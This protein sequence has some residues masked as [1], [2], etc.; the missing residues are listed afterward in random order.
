MRETAVGSSVGR[1]T[2]GYPSFSPFLSTLQGGQKVTETV[3]YARYWLPER[4]L[5]SVRIASIAV[6]VVDIENR[7]RKAFNDPIHV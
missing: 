2:V 6:V 3:T 4:V 5:R 1:G 7:A